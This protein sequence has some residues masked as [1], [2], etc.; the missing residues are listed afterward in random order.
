MVVLLVT[1]SYAGTPIVTK[2]QDKPDYYAWISSM[3]SGPI[4]WEDMTGDEDASNNT[5]TNRFFRVVITTSEIYS[6]V[7]IEEITRGSEGC[8]VRLGSIRKI[9]LDDFKNKFSLRGEISGFMLTKWNSPTS[10]NFKL[11]GREFVAKNIGN[12]VLDIEE[13]KTRLPI[14]R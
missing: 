12:E 4:E 8:C 10:F 2:P 13:T 11:G 14:S 6:T 9:N 3:S 1:P 7:Y 5:V